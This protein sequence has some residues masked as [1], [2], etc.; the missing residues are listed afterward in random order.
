MEQDSI[1]GDWC[2]FNGLP[3]H[4]SLIVH[5]L[6]IYGKKGDLLQLLH[7]SSLRCKYVPNSAN[8]NQYIATS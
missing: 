7:F 1:Q 6:F 3:V 8:I 5:M 4:R 2:S